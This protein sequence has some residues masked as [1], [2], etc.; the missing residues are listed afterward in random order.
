MRRKGVVKVAANGPEEN[1]DVDVEM[2]DNHA[3]VQAK[4]PAKSKAKQ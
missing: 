4:K 3:I 1:E 2:E